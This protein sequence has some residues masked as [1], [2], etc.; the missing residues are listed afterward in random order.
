MCVPTQC[1]DTDHPNFD[2]HRS[3]FLKLLKIR[4]SFVVLNVTDSEMV[5]IYT[6]GGFFISRD[7][8]KMN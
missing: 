7:W 1:F 5:D 2:L 3:A 8:P 6:N 4:S